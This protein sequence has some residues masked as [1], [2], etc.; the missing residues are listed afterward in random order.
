MNIVLIGFRGSG[1]STVGKRLANCLGMEF[2]DTDDLLQK[3]HGMSIREIV[4]SHGWEYFRAAEKRI[5]EDISLEN[6]LVI[7]S[8]GGVV[9][10]EEN[11]TAL[12]RNGLTIWLK[13]DPK[14]LLRRMGEDPQTLGCRPSLTGKGLSEEIEELLTC[15]N[16]FYQKA[17]AFELD[18]SEMDV[19]AVVQHILE[20]THEF[21]LLKKTFNSYLPQSRRGR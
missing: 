12:R 7:A 15:R 8:G 13:A 11:V 20:M 16:P 18:T 14:T 4:G 2:A 6:H 21:S 19:E 17:S 5:V 10:D 1:K 9:L 3:Q